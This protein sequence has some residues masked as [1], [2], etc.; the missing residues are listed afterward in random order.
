MSGARGV[1]LLD[2]PPGPTSHDVVAIVRRLTGQRRAGHTG[3][4]DPAAAGVLV[5]CLGAATRAVEY[6]LAQDKE[7]RAEV[8]FGLATDTLDGMGQPVAEAPADGLT[9]GDVEAVLARFRGNI[10]QVPPVVS[11]IKVGGQ[12]LY[13]LARQGREVQPEPRRVTIS[14]LELVDFQPG[15]RPRAIIDVACSKGTYI[16]SLA[17]DLG[18]AVGLPAFLSFLLRRRAGSFRLEDCL[19]LE[20]LAA[21]TAAGRLSGVLLSPD[22]ALGHLP[23][24]TV[25]ETQAAGLVHGRQPYQMGLAWAGSGL[26]RLSLPG[27]DLVALAEASPKG[28]TTAKVLA[29]QE[30]D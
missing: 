24:L 16:R 15:M 19:S 3:T 27:G 2:K 11:A 10:Q 22:E 14:H 8:T 6:L 12:R 21:V 17:R 30:T 18:E 29:G 25:D 28:L 9:A 7:Y 13:D 20:E 23:K 4:L 5:V 1:L 26:V